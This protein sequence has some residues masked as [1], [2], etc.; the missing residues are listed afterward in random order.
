MTEVRAAQNPQGSSRWNA[1]EDISD[2]LSH[3][4]GCTGDDGCLQVLSFNSSICR[5]LKSS[6]VRWMLTFENLHLC[7]PHAQVKCLYLMIQ[8][9][10]P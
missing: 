4:D 6:M 1:P 3:S 9:F 8:N 7:D 10:S 2:I 5:L